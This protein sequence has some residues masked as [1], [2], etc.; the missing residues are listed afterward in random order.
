M[1]SNEGHIHWPGGPDEE[2][3]Y[4]NQSLQI[5]AEVSNMANTPKSDPIGS[6]RIRLTGY[7][8]AGLLIPTE[9]WR[10]FP[11]PTRRWRHVPMATIPSA[12]SVSAR[13]KEG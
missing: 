6:L 12:T 2:V 1:P 4:L 7:G 8:S 10:R 11:A 5:T 13:L 9:G 3:T